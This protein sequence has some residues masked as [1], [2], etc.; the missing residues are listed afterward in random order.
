MTTLVANS[1][2]RKS[3]K[4]KKTILNKNPNSITVTSNTVNETINNHSD[5]F[6]SKGSDKFQVWINYIIF[7]ILILFICVAYC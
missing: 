6:R 4:D 2:G 3:V 7:I 5:E 1:S